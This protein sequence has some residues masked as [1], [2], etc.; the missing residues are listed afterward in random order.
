MGLLMGHKIPTYSL[1]EPE[2]TASISRDSFDRSRAEIKSRESPSSEPGSPAGD[3]ESTPGRVES[4]TAQRTGGG[5][6][7]GATV[8]RGGAT[9]TLATT[10]RASSVQQAGKR[11]GTSSS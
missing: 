5:L 1:V 2:N 8:Q 3:T 9:C 7:K 4:L 10:H 11:D 6:R